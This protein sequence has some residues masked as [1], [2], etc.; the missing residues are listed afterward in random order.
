MGERLIFHV[1]VN[2]AFLSWEAARRVKNGEDDLRLI[3]SCVGGDPKTRRGI[4]LAKSIPAKRYDVKTGE[5]L[6][7]ALRKCPELVIVKPDF[8]LYTR[9]S[10]AFKDICRAY[11]PAVEE[12]S[13]DEC[14]M[15][16]TGTELTYPDPI[17]LAYAIKD[18][19]RDELGFTVNIGVARSKLC[20]KMASDFEKPDRVHTL[21]PEEIESKM[22]PL[23]VGSLL[24]VGSASVSR[25]REARILTIGD[26]ARAD[27]EELRRLLGDKMSRQAR[28]YANGIDDS[29]V[30]QEREE[31][32]GYSNSVTLEE[33]VTTMEAADAILLALCDSVS[34]HMRS[35]GAKAGCVSVTVRYLDFANRSHQRALERPTD[36]TN[37]LY[38][39]CRG[40]L[41]ELWRDKRP[42]RLLGVSL[43]ELSRGGESEQLSLFGEEKSAESERNR[44][45]DRTVDALRS[46]FGS[47]II[48]RGAVLGSGVRVARKFKGKQDAE[49][50]VE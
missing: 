43:T 20:A 19:I 24:F 5:P 46:K 12:F 45:I 27:P 48:Q 18:R 35:E 32:K 30:R 16:L 40:L 47:D 42:L 8:R 14:F 2:S 3:P 37:E 21:F 10:R 31:A 7:M 38:A 11:A 41:R 34:A 29:P 13:I 22:W 50:D 44:K 39:I 23:P 26:L 28:R 49:Q 33:D 6:S 17:A 4:V 15:D 1:D 25:L 36:A 9:C